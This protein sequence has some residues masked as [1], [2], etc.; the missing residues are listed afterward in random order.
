MD[1]SILQSVKK[2]L[3]IMEEDTPFDLDIKIHINS[4]LA[5][6]TQLGVGPDEG[7]A[8]ETGHEPWSNFIGDAQNLEMIKTYVYLKV[9][10]VFDPPQNSTVLNAFKEQIAEYE[11]R[12]HYIVD[13]GVK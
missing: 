4:A 7:Y 10:Y 1:E 2:M 5:V 11:S 13:K 12:I 6:L 9:R 8:I 3:G